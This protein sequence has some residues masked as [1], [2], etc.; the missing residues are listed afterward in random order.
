MTKSLPLT[1]QRQTF[2]TKFVFGIYYLCKFINKWMVKYETDEKKKNTYI[3]QQSVLGGYS[4]FELC[5]NTPLAI[6]EI[7]G[8]TLEKGT[9]W[10]CSKNFPNPAAAN[11]AKNFKT[12]K[13]IMG[14]MLASTIIEYLDKTTNEPIILV[15][16]TNEVMCCGDLND[17]IKRLN[18]QTRQDYH[19]QM[20]IREKYIRKILEK[21]H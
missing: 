2:L 1:F 5:R 18:H 4:V 3:V 21:E 15:F 17:C 9:G 7:N 16:P 20:R 11:M 14:E 10:L 8:K 6:V 12:L 19:R 13:P